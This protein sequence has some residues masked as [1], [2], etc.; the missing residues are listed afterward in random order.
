MRR[1]PKTDVARADGVVGRRTGQR[2]PA[3]ARRNDDGTEAVDDYFASPPSA[4]TGPRRSVA[5][6]RRQARPDLAAPNGQIGRKTGRPIQEAPRDRS[7]LEDAFRQRDGKAVLH[8][9]RELGQIHH[10]EGR[11][12]DRLDRRQVTIMTRRNHIFG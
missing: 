9:V 4:R 5:I 12:C 11:N 10:R 8:H 1:G 7:G 6:Q 2:M 3:D